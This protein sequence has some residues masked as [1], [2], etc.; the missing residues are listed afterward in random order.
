MHPD[1]ERADRM[2]EFWGY[3]EN[4]RKRVLFVMVPRAVPDNHRTVTHTVVWGYPECRVFDT[5][6]YVGGTSGSS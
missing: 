2:G 1:F 3:P 4:V 6:T 5:S